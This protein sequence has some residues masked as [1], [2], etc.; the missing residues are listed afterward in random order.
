MGSDQML[1]APR[2]YLAKQGCRLCILQMAVS[3]PDPL[4]ENRWITSVSYTH[5]DVYKRQAKSWPW[6]RS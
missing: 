3:P 6:L 5:L 2:F 4:L 1:Q